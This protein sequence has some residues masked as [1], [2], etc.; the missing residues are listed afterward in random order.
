VSPAAREVLEFDGFR[1]AAEADDPQDRVWLREFLCPWLEP[2]GEDAPA[3]A[4]VSLVRD[5]GGYAKAEGDGPGVDPTPV[6]AFLA[7]GEPMSLQRWSEGWLR[8]PRSEAFLLAEEEGKAFRVLARPGRHFAR[9]LW[10]RVVRELV[11]EHLLRVG[12]PIL[13]AAAVAWRGRAV[14][15]A[16]ARRAGKS[17]CLLHS[18]Q[19]A[20]CALL[21]ND[22]LA[23]LPGA[24]AN[25]RGIPT[26]VRLRGGSLAFHPALAERI[27]RADFQVSDAIAEDGSDQPRWQRGEAAV[28]ISAGQLLELLQADGARSAPVGA[29]VFPRV[30]GEP[31]GVCLTRLSREDARAR[32]PEARLFPDPPPPT[33]FSGPR[34]PGAAAVEGPVAEALP[35]LDAALGQDA[36]SGS[37][38][39]FLAAILEAAA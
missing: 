19:A 27:G 8:D 2:L 30:T 15:F 6:A 34:S 5:E 13:H 12:R 35:C 22:R 31:G 17:S 7:D 10:M 21:G 38:E 3:D 4:R 36:Y 1:V 37:P 28:G 25:A 32:L 18:L 23:L 16:G 26:I 29:L 33:L 11:T 20:G 9:I 14:V 24:P 39:R